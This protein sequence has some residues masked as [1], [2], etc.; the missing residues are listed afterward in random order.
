MTHPKMKSRHP[1]TSSIVMLATVGTVLAT[2]DLS[3]GVVLGVLLS[4][5]FFAGKVARLFSV[6]RREDNQT[7]TVVYNVHGQIFF[8][9]AERF[10]GAFDFAKPASK[11]VIDVSKAHLWDITAVGALDKVVMKFRQAGTDVQVLGFND[12]SAEMIDRFALHDKEER[13]AASASLH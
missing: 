10:V 8:A 12:A 7:G 5:I 3:K 13:A 2:Q 11:V 4:G 1:G 6:D 9:S